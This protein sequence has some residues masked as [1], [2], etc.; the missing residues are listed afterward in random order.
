MLYFQLKGY[1]L[2]NRFRWLRWWIWQS[3]HDTYRPQRWRQVNQSQFIDGSQFIDQSQFID[4]YLWKIDTLAS[5]NRRRRMKAESRQI[6]Q[7][8]PA[9]LK[10]V[11]CRRMIALSYTELML[12]WNSDVDGAGICVRIVLLIV[13]CLIVCFGLFEVC[14]FRLWQ[15]SHKSAV[16]NLFWP[17]DHLFK[18][19]PMGHFAMLTPHEQLVETC[20]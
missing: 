5:F 11:C 1:E 12:I 9:R 3:T 13:I 7:K 4:I 10:F 19:Y 8:L 17:M 18:K 16:H 15:D 2:K 20:T 14:V 6:P